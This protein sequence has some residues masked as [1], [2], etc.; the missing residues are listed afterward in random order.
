VQYHLEQKDFD[1][2]LAVVEAYR[3]R[4]PDSA[5]P[6]NLIGRVQLAAG[7]EADA[8]KAFTRAREIEPGNPVAS[9]SLAALAIR[10]KA[11]QEARGY[12][13]DVLEYHED[14]LSTLLKLA[15]LDGVEK[16]EQLMLEHIQQAVTTHPKSVLP[17]VLLARYYLTQGKPGK[18][19][20][21]MLELSEKQ[22]KDPAVLQVIALAQ[23]AQKQYPE[24]KY[25]LEQLVEQRPKSAQVHFMFARAYAGLGDRAGLRKEL[26]STIELAPRHFAARLALARLLLLE[27]EKE[28]VT[29]QLA[30][31]NELSPD[32]ADVLRLKA[33]LARVQGDPAKASAL[34]EDIFEMSPS[35]DSMLSVARQKWAMGKQAA[36]LE[37]Q[38]QWVKEHPDDLTATLAL[39]DA[40]SQQE[41]VEPAIAQYQRVLAKDEQNVAALNGLAWQLRNKQPARA[42]EYAER[43][44]RLAPESALVLDTFAVVLLK[45][46]QVKRAKRNIERVYE[47]KPNEP[48]VRYHR[49]MIDA[50]AGDKAAAIEALQTLLSEGDDFTEK[51]EAQQLLAELQ[52]GG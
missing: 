49:A 27:G 47:K 17:K 13:Q 48:A 28:K 1:K 38:K 15:A 32:H 45:N 50:A 46:G 11:Y 36:A 42:L 41:Q 9:H 16:K 33:S 23:L 29:E 22:R 20:S 37:L 40:Y 19:P 39:A 43:A 3:L 51:S 31:L 10:K 30:V 6:Y 5:G 35:T 26:E 18:V 4:N 52:A 25:G 21:L 7:Q 12:Y 8:V 2:A 44:A 24:A 34:L 14:D